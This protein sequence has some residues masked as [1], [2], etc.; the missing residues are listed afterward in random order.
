[1]LLVGLIRWYSVVVLS[2]PE[3]SLVLGPLEQSSHSDQGQPLPVISLGLPGRSYCEILGCLLPM[4]DLEMS[5][6]AMLLTETSCHL[7][8]AWAAQQKAQGSMR[9]VSACQL[10]VSLSC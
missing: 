4:L 9:S 7:Y 3:G 5:R 10:L 8:L 2:R 1:M 6:K